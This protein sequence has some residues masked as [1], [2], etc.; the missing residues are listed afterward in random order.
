SAQSVYY[1]TPSGA[2]VF[3]AGTLR[4]TCALRGSCPTFDV[5]GRT[6]QFVRMVTRNLLRGFAAGRVWRRHPALDNVSD[7]HLP[8]VNQVSSSRVATGHD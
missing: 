3:T 4:W 5:P 7:F 8:M 1:T 2:G 6:R